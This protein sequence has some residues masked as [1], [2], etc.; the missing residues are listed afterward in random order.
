MT[1]IVAANEKCILCRL[2][3]KRIAAPANL[4][5]LSE[6]FAR[7]ESPSILGGNEAKAQAGR[8]STWAAEPKESFTFRAGQIKPF[9]SLDKALSK[10]K[11]RKDCENI[12]PKEIFCGGWIGY[13]SYEL[14][15]HIEKLPETTVDDLGMP[16]IRLCFYDRLIVYDHLEKSF[17]LI[18]LQLQ[19]EAEKP[20]DKLAALEELLAE[21][22]RIR[23]PQATPVD[24]DDVD[25]THARCNMDKDDYLQTVRRIKQY[26]YDGEV[27]QINFSQRFECDYSGRPIGLYHWQNDHNPS[28]YAAY[29]DSGDFQVVSASPEMFIT[30]SGDITQTKPI[31][32]TRPRISEMDPAAAQAKRINAENFNEL[33]HSEKEQAELNMIVDLE[34]NDVARICVPGTRKVVQPRTI[35]TYPTVFHAV[36]TVAGRLRG[37]ISFCAVL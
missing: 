24:I 3:Y 23:V 33:L 21:S 18:A 22:Q 35:E 36:A 16:L 8:F 32:G 11:L 26:I 29:I 13:F 5:G 9:E 4:P 28:G 27:Y 1:K 2:N 20:E 10:Y 7:L 14:G 12:L 34:R 37:G 6:M 31:K 25:F 17:W 15:R 19:N 30:I